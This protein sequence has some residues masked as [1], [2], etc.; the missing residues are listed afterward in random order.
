M[1]I[2]DPDT[3]IVNAQIATM[4]EQDADP[5]GKVDDGAIA[6]MDGRI[7][8]LGPYQSLPPGLM[9]RAKR[10]I[11]AGGAWITPGL[12]DCH[13]HIIHGGDR[14]AEF[15]LRL[16]GASYEEIARAG[17]GIVSTVSATREADEDDLLVQAFPRVDALISEGVTTLEVKSG[18]GLE[19]ETE[20]RMLRAARRISDFFPVDVRTTFLGAHAIPAEYSDNPDAYI[21]LVCDEM[22]PKAANEGLVDAVDA[23]C[24]GIAFSPDQVRKVFEMAQKLGLPV[25]LHAE[26]LSDLKG[27]VLAAGF[28]AISVD[29]LEYVG[30][31]GVKAMAESGSVAVILPGAFYYLNETQKPPIQAFRDAGVPMAVATDCNP[32]SSPLTSMLAVMN[33]ACVLFRMT[34][35]E[36][37]LG[38][39]RIGARAL[40]L[41]DRGTLELGSRADLACWL[42]DDLVELPY[43]M[44][45]RP[46]RWSMLAGSMREEEW[47][48]W[49]E[50]DEEG[51]HA[52]HE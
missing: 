22:L 41:A 43:V 26:Q 47:E 1:N 31:D 10:L 34:P 44:G 28:G 6:I 38:A 23:F 48:D 24:E 5:L 13:T 29:H 8:W 39:T 4:V 46:L 42:V 35:E 30:E 3:L 45:A 19:T 7:S 2:P 16:K 17:G 49:D 33:M 40:G 37:L 12:I 32:G 21:D 36:A 18:Y 9:D 27:A 51:F 50:W 25:K 15:N 14:A 11:D 20:C 52:D